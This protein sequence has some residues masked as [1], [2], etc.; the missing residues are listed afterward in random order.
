MAGEVRSGPADSTAEYYGSTWRPRPP[1]QKEGSMPLP[2]ESPVHAEFSDPVFLTDL[3]TG[4]PV[5]SVEKMKR[6]SKI[7]RYEAGQAVVRQGEPVSTVFILLSGAVKIVMPGTDRVLTVV[8]D[9]GT[10]LGWS[11]VVGREIGSATLECA[12]PTTLMAFDSKDL[13]DYFETDPRAGMFFY[14][15]L[16]CEIGDRLIRSYQVASLLHDLRKGKIL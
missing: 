2:P 12:E 7:V 13:T 8:R 16:A 9:K 10:F 5:E 1:H 11:S 14:R 15:K 6:F 3:V 4:L